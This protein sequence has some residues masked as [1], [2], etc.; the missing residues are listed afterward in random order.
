MNDFIGFVLQV[1][2]LVSWGIN[3]G[4]GGCA[5]E[6]IDRSSGGADWVMNEGSQFR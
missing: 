6:K 3:F 2:G 4:G 5:C 1:L